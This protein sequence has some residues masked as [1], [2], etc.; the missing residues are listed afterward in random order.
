M[1]SHPCDVPVQGYQM[2][3]LGDLPPLRDVIRDYGLNARKSLGQHFLLDGNL[4]NRI[5]RAAGSLENK[6]VVEVGPGHLVAEHDPVL[7][8]EGLRVS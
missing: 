8:G 2:V 3:D 1:R 4:T 5:A 7:G 6:H